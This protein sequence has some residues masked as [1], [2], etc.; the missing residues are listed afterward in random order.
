MTE[1]Q[2]NSFFSENKSW[3]N[4][5]RSFPTSHCKTQFFQNEKIGNE[6]ASIDNKNLNTDIKSLIAN[7]VIKE[8]LKK[9]N[10]LL[11]NL[12]N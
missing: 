9:K 12:S 11:A 2:I 6:Q 3:F 5:W 8:D 7:N 1:K 4:I 10:N